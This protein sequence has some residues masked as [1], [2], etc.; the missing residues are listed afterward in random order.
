MGQWCVPL[1]LFPS[2]CLPP[3]PQG[4]ATP[5]AWQDSWPSQ[6]MGTNQRKFNNV[7]GSHK[8][9]SKYPQNML[10]HVYPGK[11]SD[12]VAFLEKFNVVCELQYFKCI[13]FYNYMA[14]VW[15]NDCVAIGC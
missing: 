2:L 3:L 14:D 9:W 15:K 1:Q 5:V 6:T 10:V 7:A 11:S 12:R 8:H 4:T 13:T